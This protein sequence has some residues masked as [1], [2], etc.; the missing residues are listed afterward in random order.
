MAADVRLDV[1]RLNKF[2]SE[3]VDIIEI[4]GG[5]EAFSRL[6]EIY[7]KAVVPGEVSDAHWT[8]ILG[9]ALDRLKAKRI[10][11]AYL[12]VDE[13]NDEIPD[14]HEQYDFI[15]AHFRSI[16]PQKPCEGVML[17][18]AKRFHCFDLKGRKLE[19]DQSS[20]TELGIN[21]LKDLVRSKRC[22]RIRMIEI[23]RFEAFEVVP[24]E[25][26][27]LVQYV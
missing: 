3:K 21:A 27:G 10:G 2:R 14:W 4:L 9:I 13:T 7:Y 24:D 8:N 5:M 26:V 18:N 19:G 1:D 6:T 17:W 15:I 23:Q 22:Q 16:N 20:I 11:I 12:K 25:E